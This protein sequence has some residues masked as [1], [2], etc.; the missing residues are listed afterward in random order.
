MHIPGAVRSQVGNS[1][2]QPGLVGSARQWIGK[3]VFQPLNTMSPCWR[4]PQSD[5]ASIAGLYGALLP[6]RLPL[7]QG[8]APVE[9]KTALK[10]LFLPG[11]TAQF[12]GR[13]P[14]GAGEPRL[15]PL[16]ANSRPPFRTP[17]GASAP[18]APGPTT[19]RARG[20]GGVRACAA[21]PYIRAGAGGA[22]GAALQTG[23][24]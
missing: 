7:P 19:A 1:P 3:G 4:V 20:R 5:A 14:Q 10:A 24:E 16:K 23:A 11:Q 2:N 12:A 15:R 9:A 13:E 6:L 22:G 17:S 21:R 18:T 8:A